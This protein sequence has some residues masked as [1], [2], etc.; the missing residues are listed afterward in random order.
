MSRFSAI[1]YG[2]DYNP[3]Q[4][5]AAMGYDEEA[6]W[7]EDMRLMHLAGVNLVTVGVFSWAMHQPDE[8][9]FTFDWMD[10][11]L[12]S[13]A[14]QH[15][16]V[17]LGTGT[18]AQPQWVS[19]RYPDVLPVD[20]LGLRRRHGGRQ[21]YCPTSPDFRRLARQL[22]QQLA[23]RYQHH[24]AV[25]FWHISN[26]YYGGATDKGLPCQCERCTSSF[27]AW[28][29]QRYGTL[30]TLNQ[31]WV[32]SFWSHTYTDWGQIQF[33]GE[34]GEQSVQGLMLDYRR[35]LSD[36]YLECYLNEADVIRTVTPHIPITTNFLGAFK[37]IDYHHWAPHI[38][39]ISWDSYPTPQQDPASMAFAHDLMRGMKPGQPFLLMEQTPSQT[40]WQPYNPLKRPG[41]MRLQSY[42]AIAHG[43]DGVM[44]F[45]WRRSRGSAEMW[46][47]AI[48]NHAGDEDTRVFHEVAQLGQEL[49]AI[50]DVVAN[51]YVPSRVAILFSWPNWWAVEYQR[52]PSQDMRYLDD[53]L[54]YYRAVWSN[55][56][57]V[58]VI[59]PDADLT[60]YAIVIAPLLH[61]V[62]E[63]QGHAIER[64]VEGGGTFLTTF[65]S[66][67]VDEHQRAWLG[68]P[69]PLR[70]TLGVWI[71]EFDPLLPTMANTIEVGPESWL[72]QG[73]Y[74]CTHWVDIVRLEGAQA[75]AT[76]GGDFYQGA[77]AI[78]QHHL[79]MGAAYYVATRPTDA[80]LHVVFQQLFAHHHLNAAVKA[81]PEVEVVSRGKDGKTVVFL[82]NHTASPC[83]VPLDVPMTNLLTGQRLETLVQLAGYGVLMLEL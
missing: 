13:L 6:I 30:A 20:D 32:T 29:Q 59:P 22:V 56:I 74:P 82:L 53:V 79:G 69:G 62:T 63:A 7:R 16:A 43:A 41:I 36:I 5:S 71:E 76:F 10:R 72:P 68:A 80:L 44:F 18:A 55:H 11:L 50:G 52:G 67:A 15:I 42:Q 19:Q 3:E 27:R 25:R 61:L 38:D 83:T 8:T 73:P 39:V 31:R 81:P 40:Q 78:T 14:N 60:P 54:Q 21:N 9:T 48:V 64:F 12:D 51:T 65:H 17:C 46:H 45:Q 75:L 4:W 34:Q 35:F 37:P 26:E 57:T 2:G 58:D 77:P 47:G 28:L 66:G 33:P 24:P 23:E 1:S 70:R 49:R